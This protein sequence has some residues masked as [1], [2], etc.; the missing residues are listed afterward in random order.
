M[1]WQA[2]CDLCESM[3]YSESNVVH[4]SLVAA[5][6]VSRRQQSP[7]LPNHF[8]KLLSGHLNLPV[9]IILHCIARAV[10][11]GGAAA[12]VG[13][14]N[15]SSALIATTRLCHLNLAVASSQNTDKRRGRPSSSN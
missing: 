5:S 12:Y 9:E 4:E 6:D 10:C 15:I 7:V 8:V 1:S 2:R 3:I 11:V 14:S 13:I